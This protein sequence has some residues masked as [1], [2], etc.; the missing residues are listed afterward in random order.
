MLISEIILEVISDVGADSTDTVLIGKM[1]TFAKG[2]LRR[3][4]LFTKSRLLYI[5]SYATLLSGTNYLTTPTYFLDEKSVWYEESGNRQIIDKVTDDEFARIVNTNSSGAPEFYRIYNNVIEFDKNSDSNRI[6]YVEHLGEVDNITAS[7][8]F[9]GSTD[10][11]EILKDGMKASYYSDYV[12][13]PVK[14]REKLSLFQAGLDKLE[15]R[16][17]IETKGGHIGGLNYGS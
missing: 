11:L 5:T 16:H 17:M 4:P 13:D 15:E 14:G 6:I 8:D 10:I 7:S 2:S 9:F 12:E 1:L 3:F